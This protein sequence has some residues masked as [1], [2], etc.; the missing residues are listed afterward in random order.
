MMKKR[1]FTLSPTEQRIIDEDNYE[2]Y[3]S[4]YISSDGSSFLQENLSGVYYHSSVD[5]RKTTKV[6]FV[7]ESD[8]SKDQIL[9]DTTNEIL[10]IIDRDPTIKN[11]ILIVRVKFRSANLSD[12]KSLPSY[13]IQIFLHQE[14]FYDPTVHLLQPKMELLS[15]DESKKFL[16]QNPD[17][18]NIKGI[19]FDD[20]VI[21]FLGGVF[22]QII[23]VERQLIYVAQVQK[24]MEY[25]MVTRT[26]INEYFKKEDK[27]IKIKQ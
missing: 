23:R 1:G 12:L 10:A 3:K 4:K 25:R 13:N 14:L 11:I 24:S 5:Q 15:I 2:L 20:P 9:T 26:S 16:S 27:S 17:N 7:R 21:K 18:R 6:I 22:D 19:C 8:E